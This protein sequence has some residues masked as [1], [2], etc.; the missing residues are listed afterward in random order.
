M[1]I[2]CDTLKV[3]QKI[4]RNIFP[5]G[6]DVDDFDDDDDD[7]AVNTHLNLELYCSRAVAVIT[8]ALMC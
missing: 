5:A 1:H 7:D 2:D 4:P 6:I 3:S 8:F